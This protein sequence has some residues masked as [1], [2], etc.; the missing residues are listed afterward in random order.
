VIWQTPLENLFKTTGNSG[1][2]IKGKPAML[3]E[4]GIDHFF[5]FFFQVYSCDDEFQQ[6]SR[7]Q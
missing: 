5:L 4:S 6:T 7:V 2:G 1:R 3:H